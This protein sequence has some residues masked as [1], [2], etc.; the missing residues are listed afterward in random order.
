MSSSNPDP[1]RPSKK[2]DGRTNP[3]IAFRRFADAQMSSLVNNVFG[4]FQSS[5]IR[6]QQAIDNFESMVKQQGRLTQDDFDRPIEKARRDLCLAIQAVQGDA[7]EAK[8][9]R[10]DPEDDSETPFD[11]MRCPYRPPERLG[12]LDHMLRPSTLDVGYIFMSPYSPLALE[13]QE[14]FREH[15]GKMRAA[16]ADLVAMQEAGA[17]LPNNTIEKHTNSD[18]LGWAAKMAQMTAFGRSCTWEGMPDRQHPD[19]LPIRWRLSP[20][21]AELYSVHEEQEGKSDQRAQENTAQ[22]EDMAQALGDLNMLSRLQ[23][24]FRR[25]VQNNQKENEEKPDDSEQEVTLRIGGG[26][27]SVGLDL[28]D[29][30]AEPESKR[31]DPEP[32]LAAAQFFPAE[33]EDNNGACTCVHCCNYERRREEFRQWRR[34]ELEE[35]EDDGDS[36]NDVES[37][38]NPTSELDQYHTLA[39]YQA[40]L[41]KLEQQN[42]PKPEATAAASGFEKEGEAQTAASPP[43]N[44]SILSTLTTTEQ[45]TLPDGTV[46]T[47]VVLK[48][49]F[50][51]GAEEVTERVHTQN[52]PTP[53]SQG[54]L[55]PAAA[56]AQGQD[57]APETSRNEKKLATTTDKKQQGGWFW[58]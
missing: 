2:D 10:A 23:A 9:P 48:K 43:T 17:L 40:H 58:S 33:A 47:K 39:D 37:T 46:T 18:P 52:A 49:R 30:Q 24:A 35:H 32:I 38:T 28:D 19:R 51:D 25:R 27:F 8:P 34:E 56:T 13:R 6:R 26:A 44:P 55:L 7:D 54:T 45:R 12:L 21:S 22:V 11:G 1:D 3:F 16:F 41:L 14:I 36:D 15:S 42:S 31:A 4:I 57:P 29:E 53:S 5:P 20:M 50:S